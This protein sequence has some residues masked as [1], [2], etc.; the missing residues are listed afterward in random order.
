[1]LKHAKSMYLNLYVQDLMLDIS[2][3]SSN[4]AALFCSVNPEE[5]DSRE[6]LSAVHPLWKS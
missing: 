2:Q 5:K 3:Y 4:N 6:I 1:M